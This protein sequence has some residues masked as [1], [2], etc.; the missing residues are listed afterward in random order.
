MK[1]LCTA[2]EQIDMV[3][4]INQIKVKLQHTF[5]NGF[6]IASYTDLLHHTNTIFILHINVDSTLK[7]EQIQR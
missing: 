1:K 7:H 2:H 3:I 5:W 4:K 6:T